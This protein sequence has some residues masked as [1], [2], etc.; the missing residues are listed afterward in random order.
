MAKVRDWI[1]DPL[2]REHR[3]NRNDQDLWMRHHHG[4]ERR[5]EEPK[6]VIGRH[7]KLK[8]R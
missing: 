6:Q 2:A 5:D 4:E 8:S 1:G 3:D 7:P